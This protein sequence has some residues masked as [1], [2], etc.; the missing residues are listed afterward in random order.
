MSSTTHDITAEASHGAGHVG[1]HIPAPKGDIIHDWT[2]GGLHITN[3]V[4]STWLFMGFL[5]ILVAILYMAITTD[6]LPGV[7][8]LGLDVVNRILV[9][10]TELVGDKGMAHRYMWLLGGLMVVVFLGNI[11]GLLLDWLVIVSAGNWL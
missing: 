4:F 1:P 11:F 10:A 8:A 7:K 9:Y 2:I 6:K 5:F 3:T